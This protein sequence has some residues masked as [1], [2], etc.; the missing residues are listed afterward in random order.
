M[1]CTEDFLKKGINP[2]TVS[3][4]CNVCFV[5]EVKY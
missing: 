1:A 4:S 3:G 5:V 2:S